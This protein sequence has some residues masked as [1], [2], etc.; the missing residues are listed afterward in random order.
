[1]SQDNSTHDG[2]PPVS[3]TTQKQGWRRRISNK[4]DLLE[5]VKTYQ[6]AIRGWRRY[7]SP[8][9][10]DV[11]QFILDRSVGWGDTEATFKNQEACQQTSRSDST[12]RNALSK[13]CEKGAITR[14]QYDG[15]N[16]TYR[17]NLDWCADHEEAQATN[18]AP[19]GSA[20]LSVEDQRTDRQSSST[21]SPLNGS[22]AQE[23]KELVREVSSRSGPGNEN[24]KPKNSLISSPPTKR[25][26]PIPELE[27]TWRETWAQTFDKK[28]CPQWGPREFGIAKNFAQR[29]ADQSYRTAEVKKLVEFTLRNWRWIVQ[30][31][32]Q[33]M[34]QPPAP[35]YPTIGFLAH[36]LNDIIHARYEWEDEA[37]KPKYDEEGYMVMPDLTPGELSPLP[38][39]DELEEK[40]ELDQRRRQQGLDRPPPR[41]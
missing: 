41:R 6:L 32:F 27:K 8:S 16:T 17:I 26:F 24:K 5:R 31:Q 29:L 20:D 14:L 22:K 9:E 21:A 28:Y 3:V 38:S 39:W 37:Q 34:K 4:F 13:L 23:E 2:V 36:F 10:H 19:P 33:W 30:S 1:M 35:Q 15:R 40:K 12:V 7:L 11:L 18:E 25:A